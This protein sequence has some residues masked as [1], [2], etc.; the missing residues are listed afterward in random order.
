[1]AAMPAPL[2]GVAFATKFTGDVTVEPSTGAQTT[3]PGA[4]G[5]AHACC[6]VAFPVSE[7][8]CGLPL[9]ES[10]TLSVPVRGPVWLGV[11]LTRMVQLAPEPR[12][13]GQLFDSKKSP[14]DSMLE[15][16]SVP[17]PEL[18]RVTVCALLEVPICW[19]PKLRLVGE[20]VAIGI[21]PAEVY[22]NAPGSVAR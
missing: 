14:L 13:A 1:M 5:A 12:D 2:A 21:V 16:S 19:L 6:V 17:A 15:I 22:V 10:V 9:A 3:T 7:T 11:K 18:L 8:V 20:R 4:D